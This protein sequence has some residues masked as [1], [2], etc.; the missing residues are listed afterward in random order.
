MDTDPPP[1]TGDRPLRRD[2]VRNRAR[3]L[4]AAREVFAAR[5]LDAT[6]D[7]VAAHAGVGV[8][9]VYRRFPGKAE[10][11][12]TLFEESMATCA[13]LAEAALAE[14][15]PA[16]AL[17]GL[18]EALAE[19]HATDHGLRDVMSGETFGH[20]RI[21]A[22][23]RRLDAAVREVIVRAQR[24]GDVHPDLDAGDFP[25]LMTMISA[26]TDLGRDVDPDLWRRYVPLL[27]EAIRPRPGTP[28]RLTHP[29][30]DDD[31]VE[32]AMTGRGRRR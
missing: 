11:V 15:D 18:V 9:T 19:R 17:V 20:D 22:S 14:A 12:Q 16:E 5:G 2:A 28:R 4:V 31:Q 1:V 21:E 30:L 29:P 23:R 8:G 25:V 24:S 27:L 32:R 13:D 26:V 10:L 7:D 6:L 3:I